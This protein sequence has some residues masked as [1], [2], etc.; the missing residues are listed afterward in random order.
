MPGSVLR[1]ARLRCTARATALLALLALCAL[2]AAGCDGSNPTEPG[3]A[4]SACGPY[5]P[6]Q[7][8]PYVLPYPAGSGFVVSQGNCSAGSHN[9]P[10]RHAYDFA[11]PIG[12]PVIAARSGEV[13]VVIS[14]RPDTA[15]PDT[16]ENVVIVLHDDG[17]RAFYSHLAQRSPL[18]TVG[19]LVSQRQ[20]IALSGNSGSTG[21]L[22]HLHFQVTPCPDRDLCGT[23][24]VTFLN[25]DP[26]PDGLIAGVVY[27]AR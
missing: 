19:D 24:P 3:R 18:V 9:G 26:N 14:D 15:D 17:T 4:A 23:L 13:V 2:G 20:P 22:P 25:T 11:M 21:N 5:P 1:G 27:P 12:S 16:G 6:W 8:S 7:A 10:A